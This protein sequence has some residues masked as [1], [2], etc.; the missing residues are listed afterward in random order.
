MSPA[1][2]GTAPGARAHDVVLLGAT[3]FTGGLTASHLAD[4]LPPG[5]RWALAGRDRSRL[6]AVRDRLAADHPGGVVP[7]LLHGDVTDPASLRAVAE[8]SRVLAT[9]VG[10]YLQHGD[11]VVA[12]CAA[13]GTDY[14]DLTGEPEFVDRTW[15]AHHA[16]AVATGAR[17]VHSCGF[18]AVPPDLGVLLTVQHLPA[19]VPLRVRGVVRGDGAAS[20]GTLASALGQ[21]ARPR[22]SREAAGARRAAEGR[23]ADG[24]R[25]RSRPGRPRRDRELGAWLLPLPTIDH[26]VVRRSAAARPDY[27]PDFAYEHHAGFPGPVSAA[28]TAAVVAGLAGAAQVPPARA[29]LQRRLVQGS[30][31]DEERRARSWFTVDLVGEGGGERVHTRVAGGDP[32]YGETA[33][34]L[35]ET[36]LSLAFDEDNPATA[37][38]V[39]PA[40]AVGESLLHRLRAVGMQL[41][42]VGAAAR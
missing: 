1:S 42:V 12:A 10:P 39:T 22:A 20:G 19:G 23:P 35:A 31:P 34:M 9:T 14:A 30:G 40:A 29:L 6:E 24:R 32:G 26:L 28:G 37:G 3:G 17:L 13:A 8:A 7:D 18:E 21:V 5:S 41:D 36:V 25:V 16:T 15:L 33:R 2:S 38:Q 27:G 4:H 11:A